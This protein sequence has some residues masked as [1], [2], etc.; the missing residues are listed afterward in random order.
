MRPLADLAHAHG[1]LFYTDAV[2]A[3][4]MFPVDV[5]A[6]GVDCHDQRHLQVAARRI[7]RRAVLHPA[8]A[9]RAHP[10]RP[11]RRAAR[12]EGASPTIA[13]RFIAPRRSSSTRRCRSPRSTSWAPALAYLERVGVDRIEQHTR[14]AGARA[15]RGPGGARLP[16]VHAARQQVVDR[17]HPLDK[18][19]ARAKEVLDKAGV[20]VSFREEG[21][22]DPRV[23]GPVQH[24]RRDSAVSRRCEAIRV[25]TRTAIER[26]AR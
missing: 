13:S 19:Q 26:R 10:R 23:A 6:A 24:A 7:R 25:A 17:Q 1:A 3:L 15:A 18:N 12:R 16:D 11:A 4:G 20:Q 8:R 5:R 2:Q 14:G 9:A 22:H 21:S